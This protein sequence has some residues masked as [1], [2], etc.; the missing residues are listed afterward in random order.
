MSLILPALVA[1]GHCRLNR[2]RNDY[3]RCSARALKAKC[4]RRRYRLTILRHS[5]YFRQRS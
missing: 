3:A 1:A 2:D 5:R 4:L